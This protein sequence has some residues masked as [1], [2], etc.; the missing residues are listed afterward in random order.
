MGL[1]DMNKIE[2]KFTYNSIYKIR[3]S[4]QVQWINAILQ[5]ETFLSSSILWARSFQMR[6]TP[7]RKIWETLFAEHIPHSNWNL[8]VLS[9]LSL[10]N[11]NILLI[12]MSERC[13]VLL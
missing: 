3:K 6:N 11:K 2:G 9:S 5:V 1:K 8:G 12:D 13:L 7:H 4:Y 10:P